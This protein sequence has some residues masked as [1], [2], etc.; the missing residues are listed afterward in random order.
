M[1]LNNKR[2]IVEL[3]NDAYDSVNNAIRVKVSGSTSGSS[4]WEQTGTDLHPKNQNVKTI[5]LDNTSYGYTELKIKNEDDTTN[6]SG[7]VLELKGSGPDYSNNIYL[8]KY[9]ANYWISELSDSGSL[10]TDNKLNIGAV[11]KNNEIHFLLGT[12]YQHIANQMTFNEDG[13]KYINDLSGANTVNP[14]WLPDKEY[15]DNK[16]FKNVYTITNSSVLNNTNDVVRLDSSSNSISIS[17][18]QITTNNDGKIFYIKTKNYVNSVD[19]NCNSGDTFDDG[20]T[21][22]SFSATNELITIVADLDSNQWV[23][24]N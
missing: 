21:T 16:S 8:G 12:D 11:G 22:Y 9:G 6:Y 10:L 23:R 24:L 1:P 4:L 20:T 17:L 14:R 7:A 19:V 3:L 18:P 5:T 13:L 15:V 2:T